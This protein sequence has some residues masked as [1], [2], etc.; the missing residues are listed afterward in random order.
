MGKAS[1]ARGVEADTACGADNDVE[2]GKVKK[3]VVLRHDE[4][5]CRAV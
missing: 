1:I 5:F 3:F 4:L 2:L